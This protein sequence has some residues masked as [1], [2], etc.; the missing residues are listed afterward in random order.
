M[1]RRSRRETKSETI[2]ERTSPS[3]SAIIARCAIVGELLRKLR[4]AA[5]AFRWKILGVCRILEM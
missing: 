2:E 1:Y 3:R 5:N 4:R